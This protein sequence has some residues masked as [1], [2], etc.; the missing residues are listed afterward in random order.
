MIRPPMTRR[1]SL[2]LAAVALVL[3]GAAVAAYWFWSA[4]R[5]GQRIALW[6]EQQRKQGYEIT[7]GGPTITGFPLRLEAR[8]DQPVIASPKGWRWHGPGI[9]GQAA[10]W[11][12][13]T[14]TVDFSG[15]HRIDRGGPKGEVRVTAEQASGVVH[16]RKD[17]QIDHAS[18]ETGALAVE[19]PKGRFSV[20]RSTWRLGPLTP[21][22][23]ERP[24]QLLFAGEIESLDLP[25]KKAGPLGPRVQ[26][27]AVG[28]VLIG[29]IPQGS[30]RQMLKQWRDAGG[31]LELGRVELDWGPLGLDG[32]GTIGL[33]QKF[34]PLGA[35]TARL[36]GLMKTL[37]LLI[38]A[39]FLETGQ[40]IPA[41]IAL[42]ALGGKKDENGERVIVLPVTLQDGQLYLG[43]APLMRISPIL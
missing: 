31:V 5:L 43:P 12:P 27:L 42:L 40:A 21:R 37:D 16:L 3:A 29:E 24:Q 22:T 33:D 7:Y 13:F 39:G 17:G 36:R 2:I 38:A 18:A 9:T 26:R 28:G 8:F 6:T 11:D 15:R 35:F 25:R 14:I 20:G 32:K 30:E 10:L 4:E 34:R 23:G 19:P 41:K 1:R